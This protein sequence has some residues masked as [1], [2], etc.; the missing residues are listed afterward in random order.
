MWGKKDWNC[1]F[2]MSEICNASRITHIE[3]L[4]QN[5]VKCSIKCWVNNTQSNVWMKRSL[6]FHVLSFNKFFFNAANNACFV[7]HHIES[8]HIEDKCH[9]H[10]TIMEF[11]EKYL[12]YEIIYFNPVCFKIHFYDFAAYIN[13]ILKQSLSTDISILCV[14]V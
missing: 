3:N 4:I 12:H 7:W 10:V 1:S 8:W 14:G 9:L 2:W 11:S 13:H 6:T 5:S